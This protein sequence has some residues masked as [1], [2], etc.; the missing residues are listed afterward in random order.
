MQ[1][2]QNECE[3]GAKTKTEKR[4]PPPLGACVTVTGT[5]LVRKSHFSEIQLVCDGRTD[6]RMDRRTDAGT[7]GQTRSLIEMRR[8]I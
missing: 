7:D 1:S 2:K 5:P 8:R 3:V 4:V 6:G